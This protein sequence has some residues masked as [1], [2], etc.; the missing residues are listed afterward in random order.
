MITTSDNFTEFSFKLVESWIV[1]TKL[2][3]TSVEIE[4][5]YNKTNK[6]RDRM[7]STENSNENQT[8]IVKSLPPELELELDDN[9]LLS[10]GDEDDG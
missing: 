4:E 7:I 8:W 5:I 9:I 2:E 6:G 1:S 10:C 3:I